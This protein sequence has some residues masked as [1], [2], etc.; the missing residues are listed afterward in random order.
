M[1]ILNMLP[2][3]LQELMADVANIKLRDVHLGRV[4]EQV[5]LHLAHAHDLDPDAALEEDESEGDEEEMAPTPVVK[6]KRK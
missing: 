2:T 6:G 4:L 3:E 5:V 1:A